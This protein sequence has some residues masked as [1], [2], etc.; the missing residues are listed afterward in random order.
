MI[1]NEDTKTIVKDIE[2][3]LKVY[4]KYRKVQDAMED[5]SLKRFVKYFQTFLA[6]YK[7]E[8]NYNDA[9][10]IGE[11]HSK[12]IQKNSASGAEKWVEAEQ[13]MN[14]LTS[15]QSTKHDDIKNK[16]SKIISNVNLKLHS[17]DED[18]KYISSVF[19]EK[20]YEVYVASGGAWNLKSIELD[21]Y[22]QNMIEQIYDI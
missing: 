8:I 21:Y 20:E 15:E 12:F 13:F 18:E 5:K 7:T 17:T 9:I 10:E 3:A 11:I 6:T 14:K 1:K 4:W 2:D 16:I 19:S 22:A